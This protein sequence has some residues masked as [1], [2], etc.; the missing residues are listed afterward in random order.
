MQGYCVFIILHISG[1]F[2]TMWCRL[3][4][5][6][7][8][9]GKCVFWKPSI[10]FVR[11]NLNNV[12]MMSMTLIEKIRQDWRSHKLLI[13]HNSGSYQHRI[14]VR[15]KINLFWERLVNACKYRRWTTDFELLTLKF[16]ILPKLQQM[17]YLR[18]F[19]RCKDSRYDFKLSKLI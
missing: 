14:K 19:A 2:D 1:V 16:A 12:K 11:Q 9:E 4:V 5:C 13:A 8:N 17:A 15:I 18:Q 3:K 10:K 6:H 7:G